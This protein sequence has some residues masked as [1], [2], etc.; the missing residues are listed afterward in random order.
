MLYRKKVLFLASK[1]SGRQLNMIEGSIWDKVLMFALPVALTGILQQCFNAADVAVVGSF[2][3][4]NAMAA[5]SS[6]SSLILLIVGLFQGLSMGSNV[7][8]AQYI[9]QR[10]NTKVRKAVHTSVLLSVLSG[11]IVLILGEILA[12]PMLK[13]MNVPDTVLPLSTIYLRIYFAG[14]P[15]IML[16]NFESAIFRSFGDTRTPLI[17]LI[18]SGVINVI[19][20]LFFVLVCGMSVEGVAIATVIANIISSGY[21]FIR[22]M[23]SEGLIGISFRE[24]ALDGSIVNHIIS[25][26]VP[27]G[28]QGMVF[29][30]SNVV[31]QSGINSLGETVMAGSGAAF[32]I[33][34][35]AY[36][37][38]NGFGQASVTFMGQNYGHG[39]KGRC[40]RVFKRCFWMDVGIAIAISG[41]LLLCGRPLLHLFNSDAAVI[42]AGMVRLWMILPFEFINAGGMEIPSGSLRGL[43][44]S[45]APAI[46]TA[47]GVCGIR[48]VW[49]YTYFVG[50]QTFQGLMTC[51]PLSWIITAAI[52]LPYY[53]IVQKKLL[54]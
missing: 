30:I 15:V 34:I 20:N 29:S 48:I 22:M 35:I 26:G 16:Y 52:L 9:G 17:S 36:F 23:K 19:L 2:V 24:M 47:I 31:V 44:K 33:E 45:M 18:I 46:I 7:V 42:D 38:I 3:G 10:D 13:L 41:I 39:D 51:Y 37:V 53:L 54:S 25:I 49:V 40:R 21:L 50:H 43:G 4:A 28:L 1:T 5:V 11:F 8:I 32:N 12:V 6:N 14:M 27:A